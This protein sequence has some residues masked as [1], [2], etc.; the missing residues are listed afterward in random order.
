L[1]H[2]RLRNPV[3]D[4]TYI[5]LPLPQLFS[6]TMYDANHHC[7]LFPVISFPAY[8]TLNCNKALPLPSTIHGPIYL[9]HPSQYPWRPCIRRVYSRHRYALPPL[10]LVLIGLAPAPS[11][12]DT[13]S[14][15]Q[16]IYVHANVSNT[17][18]LLHHAA[19]TIVIWSNHI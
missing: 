19:A 13:T 14:V 9:L 15:K 1:I 8:A 11:G 7:A 4:R 17:Q 5:M 10:S 16:V 12:T 2:S 6:Q 18:K 3:R